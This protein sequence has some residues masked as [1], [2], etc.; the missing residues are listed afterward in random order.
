MLIVPIPP[1]ASHIHALSETPGT[2]ICHSPKAPLTSPATT[3]PPP[4]D[5]QISRF[6]QDSVPPPQGR[7]KSPELLL[8]CFLPVLH[9]SIPLTVSSQG[10][11]YVDGAYIH[12]TTSTLTAQV[13]KSHFCSQSSYHH[14]AHTS[15]R[16]QMFTQLKRNKKSLLQ[17]IKA[18]TTT[19]IY[20]SSKHQFFIQQNKGIQENQKMFLI[21]YLT[22]N[23]Y[24]VIKVQDLEYNL[25][26]SNS[27]VIKEMQI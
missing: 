6:Y 24:F 27:L 21:I 2:Q 7:L 9:M 8:P 10:L 4:A 13:T 11:T 1:L 18:F 20:K 5:Y 12:T 25:R 19:S 15:H 14:N 16:G 23:E 26:C 17:F 22:K 3:G